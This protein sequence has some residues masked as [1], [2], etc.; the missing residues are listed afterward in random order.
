ML[1]GGE[2]IECEEPFCD[3]RLF[4]KVVSDEYC[5]LVLHG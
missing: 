2:K 5:N 3:E 1:Q 4:Q